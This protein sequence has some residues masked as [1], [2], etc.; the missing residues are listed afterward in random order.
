MPVEPPPTGWKLLPAP[1][2]HPHD[3]WALGADLAPGTLLAAYRRGL[4]PMRVQTELGWWSPIQRGIVP[5]EG[6][7]VSRSLQ[8]SRRR[9][10]LRVDTAF[11]E[12]VRACADPRRPHG[13]IDESFVEA[14]GDL[15]RLG[16]AHSIEAWDDQGLAGGL[17]GVAI[18]GLFAAESK[19]FRRTDASKVALWGLVELMR[20]APDPEHRLLDVQWLTPHLETL[21]AIEIPRAAY[22]VRLGAALQ[23]SP[24]DWCRPH[25]SAVATGS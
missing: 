12:V 7:H 21:G 25:G 10:E 16:W 24:T 6:F 8:R 17:Y 1:A 4:F 14:Y 18:G 23:L 5:L 19:F 11:D 13:W 2:D 9:F 3:L 22:L 15:H 20:A